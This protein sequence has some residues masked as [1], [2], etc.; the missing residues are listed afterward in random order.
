MLAWI[1]HSGVTE[2]RVSQV[3]NCVKSSM[4]KVQRGRDRLSL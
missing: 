1:V 3:A 4:F 2:G